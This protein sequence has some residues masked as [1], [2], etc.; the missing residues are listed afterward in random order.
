MGDW[1][2][3]IADLDATSAEAPGL[4]GGLVAWLVADGIVSAERTDCVFGADEGHP[5]GPRYTEAFDGPDC[6]VLTLRT[7]GLHAWSGRTVVHPGQGSVEV[8]CPRCDTVE[9]F[10][11][12]LGAA[13]FEAIDAWYAQRP[14]DTA[15]RHCSRTIAVNEWRWPDGAWAF[16]N[17]GL[18]FWNWPPLSDDFVAGI[19][20][21][22]GHRIR[23][24]AGK[25]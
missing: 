14:S 22:L 16:A 6:V 5:P 11:E 10:D 21:R 23:L 25:L 12:P 3:T 13:F 24:V 9:P 17:L 20:S 7:N 2:Q 8:G 15:C 19:G 18:T 4:A 1:F